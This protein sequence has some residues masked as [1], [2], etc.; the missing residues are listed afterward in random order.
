MNQS[1]R[2]DAAERAE[3]ARL[4]PPPGDPAL[5]TDRHLLLKDAF[6]QQITEARATRSPRRFALLAVPV[7]AAVLVAA[8]VGAAVLGRPGNGGVTSFTSPV[9]AVVAG[10]ATGVAPLMER[11]ALVAGKEPPVPVGADEYVYIKSKVAWLV[12]AGDNDSGPQQ[13]GV[14]RRVL[15]QVHDRE[16]WVPASQGSEGLIRERGETFGLTGAAPNSRYAG[17]PTDPAELLTRVYADTEGRG[18]GPNAAAF[19]FLGEALRESLLPP[20]VAAAI[21]RAAAKIPGVVLVADSVDA[22]GRHGVAVART[23]EFGEREE[24]IFD[25]RTFAYLGERSYLVRDTEDGKAGMLTATTAVLARGVVRA[26]G[27]LPE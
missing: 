22:E 16:L 4:L 25:A 14:D 26:A 6:M 1:P 2:L 5:S 19:E 8:G 11:V 18:S 21:Y 24:W 9:V 3:L 12:F 20:Q 17:L 23:D 7:A 27:D 10:D 13:A 15:D